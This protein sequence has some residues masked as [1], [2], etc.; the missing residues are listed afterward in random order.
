MQSVD[1]RWRHGGNWTVRVRRRQIDDDNDSEHRGWKELFVAGEATST[2]V[3]SL[4]PDQ[5]YLIVVDASNEVGHNA[6]LA[7]EPITIP[8]AETS[9]S[10]SWFCS[11]LVRNRTLFCRMNVV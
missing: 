11:H 10:I 7:P 8:D 9:K 6:S 5:R 1:A 2:V 4:S 3:D